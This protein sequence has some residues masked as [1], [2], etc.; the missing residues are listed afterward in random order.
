MAL[1][2]I[3]L[4]VP[5]S[6]CSKTVTREWATWRTTSNTSRI[7]ADSPMT[8][9]MPKLVVELLSERDVFRFKILLAEGAGDAHFEFIDLQPPFGDVIVRALFHGLDRD[10]S[11][12]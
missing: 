5:L 12:P 4:P 1:A 6:P 10:S 11:E 9:S 3:S 2:I 7:A 8:F